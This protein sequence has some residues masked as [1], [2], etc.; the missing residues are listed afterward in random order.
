MEVINHTIMVWI[1]GFLIAILLAFFLST[2]ISFIR[3]KRKANLYL[4]LNYLSFIG[5]MIFFFM[6]HYHVIATGSAPN[7]TDTYHHATMFAN[8]FIVV[9]II[10]LLLF[11][12]QFIKRKKSWLIAEILLGAI[13]FAWLLLPFNYSIGA[14]EGFSLR[15]ISYMLMSLYGIIVY[16]HMT[17]SFYGSIRK[18]SV[19]RKQLAALGTASLIFLA[20]FVIITIYGISQDF[21]M[22]LISMFL[23]YGCFFCYF[24]GIYLRKLTSKK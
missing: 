9:G 24:L 1:I 13:V 5:A 14:G 7:L 18:T 8:L 21:L 23:L 2:M 4:A 11:H 15:I 17:I 19:G 16:T 12:A 10:F 6:A 22:L 20:Y 3:N